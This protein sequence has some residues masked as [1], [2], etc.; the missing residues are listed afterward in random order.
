MSYRDD[1]EKVWSFG[2][3]GFNAAKQYNCKIVFGVETDN[4][5]EGDQVDFSGEDQK[6][7]YTELAKVFRHLTADHPAAGYG[8]A[9]HHVRC[10]YNL[11]KG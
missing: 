4:S 3:K 10:W 8:I 6:T 9:V 7:C 5:G 2:S 11:T 1:G